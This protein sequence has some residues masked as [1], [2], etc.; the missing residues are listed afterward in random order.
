M[1]LREYLR[2]LV[3]KPTAPLDPIGLLG[4]QATRHAKR[5]REAAKRVEKLNVGVASDL[6]DAANWLAEE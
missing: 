5:L 3:D 2:Y 6:R 4:E 1:T